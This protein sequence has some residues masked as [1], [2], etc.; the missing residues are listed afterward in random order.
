MHWPVATVEKLGSVL[1]TMRFPST[2]SANDPGIKEA[3]DT[4][5]KRTMSDVWKK[6]YD[7]R[8]GGCVEL[9]ASTS[10]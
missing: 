2:E 7:N 9:T 8:D 4:I 1:P 5:L 3:Y 6:F 10:G